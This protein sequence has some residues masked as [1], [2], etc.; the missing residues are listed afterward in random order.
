MIDWGHVV[1]AL[2]KLDAGVPEKVRPAMRFGNATK[3]LTERLPK[4][5]DF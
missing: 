2:N 3:V 5:D 1:E 4:H